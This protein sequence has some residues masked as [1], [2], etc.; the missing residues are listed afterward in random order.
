MPIR[1]GNADDGESRTCFFEVGSFNNW[2]SFH[3]SP[4]IRRGFNAPTTSPLY[5]IRIHFTHTLPYFINTPIHPHPH[6]STPP[7]HPNHLFRHLLYR[8]AFL[9]AAIPLELHHLSSHIIPPA[10]LPLQPPL[11]IH[12]LSKYTTLFYQNRIFNLIK[13]IPPSPNLLLSSHTS[14]HG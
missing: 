11:Q 4:E 13:F 1:A 5:S 14:M 7:L 2:E 9:P 3:F 8:R 12:H 10:T 6:S